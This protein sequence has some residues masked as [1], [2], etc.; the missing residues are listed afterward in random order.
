[1]LTGF[2]RAHKK[3]PRARR[4]RYPASEN[5]FEL[6]HLR[7]LP[8]TLVHCSVPSQ[9]QPDA[10]ASASTRPS[11]E[12]KWIYRD[13]EL[14]GWPTRRSRRAA[15]LAV[16]SSEDLVASTRARTAL[17]SAV[18]SLGCPRRASPPPR[19]VSPTHR[20]F[21]RAAR[22]RTAQRSHQRHE[23]RRS[24]RMIPPSKWLANPFSLNTGARPVRAPCTFDLRYVFIFERG[25]P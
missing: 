16:A 9:I 3:I 6:L 23:F 19:N 15:A 12:F 14:R 24:N 22:P 13:E 18:V 10:R 17:A 11:R 1:M 8:R 5:S 20:H 7:A 4:R 21:P 25:A 2:P